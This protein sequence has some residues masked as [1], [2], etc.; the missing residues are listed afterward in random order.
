MNPLRWFSIIESKVGIWCYVVCPLII[1]GR[2]LVT[3]SVSGWDTFDYQFPKFLYAVDSIWSGVWPTWN[4]FTNSGDFFL[5]QAILPLNPLYAPF[6]FLSKLVSPL[7]VFESANVAL[8]LFAIVG[9]R[10]VLRDIKIHDAGVHVVG[11]TLFAVMLIGPLVGQ[12]VFVFSLAAL[13]WLLHFMF[14]LLR[15]EG[16]VVEMLAWGAVLGLVAGGGY[17]VLNF[18]IGLLLLS[19]LFYYWFSEHRKTSVLRFVGRSSAFITTF[20]I[21]SIALVWPIV[22]NTSAYYHWFL[23]DLVSPDPRVRFFPPKPGDPAFSFDSISYAFGTLF[24]L[25]LTRPRLRAW[26]WGVGVGTLAFMIAYSSY[27]FSNF[28]RFVFANAHWLIAFL[29]FLICSAGSNT[30]FGQ[31]LFTNIPI[32][33]NNRFPVILA[34]LAQW[35]L[36]M[37]V[38]SALEIFDFSRRET[39]PKLRM[40]VSLAIAVIGAALG[41]SL[42][43]LGIGTFVYLFLGVSSSEASGVAAKTRIL[44]LILAGTL[45]SKTVIGYRMLKFQETSELSQKVANRKTRPEFVGNE[46]VA[47]KPVKGKAPSELDFSDLKWVLEKV[48][49]THGYNLFNH[50]LY[51]VLKNSELISQ[52]VR[53]TDRVEVAADPDRVNEVSDN[54]LLEG[55]ANRVERAFQEGSTI[56]HQDLMLAREPQL[57]ASVGRVVST[58]DRIGIDVMTNKS[59]LLVNNTKGFPGWSVYVNGKPA[60]IVATNYIF[61]GV[62]IP[63]GESHVEFRF[64]PRSLWISFVPYIALALSLA[65]LGLRW[66]VRSRSAR[67]RSQ[68]DG[69]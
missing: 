51:A 9:F 10:R 38:L 15:G 62:L 50:P 18:C 13:V 5:S 48:P 6:I 20:G 4:P 66:S 11:V 32:F 35:C 34:L 60:E 40:Y 45:L 26:H 43:W 22:E 12:I 53:I 58:P 16:D 14:R 57:Q 24:D 69:L 8:V 68:A 56:V 17:I 54:A 64:R 28:R 7:L 67:L 1:W 36:I 49:F 21:V 42:L 3:L 39:T 19:S 63:E 37:M 25:N 41:G 46:R 29:F 52:I 2:N 47:P 65:I 33:N 59:A 23:G 27:L 31:W 61:S 30:A 44:M 55:M